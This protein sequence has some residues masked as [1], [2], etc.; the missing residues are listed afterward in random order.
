MNHERAVKVFTLYEE[1]GERF[2]DLFP[3]TNVDT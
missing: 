1:F 3:L 2:A